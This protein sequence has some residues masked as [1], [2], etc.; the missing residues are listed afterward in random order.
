MAKYIENIRI[1]DSIIDLP[2][3]N[4]A[5]EAETIKATVM[6]WIN[7]NKPENITDV[8]QIIETYGA[9]VVM[10]AYAPNHYSMLPSR[11]SLLGSVKQRG[12]SRP[13]SGR[14]K[15]PEGEKRTMRSMK[16]TDAEW[17]KIK[18]FAREV[19]YQNTK[20]DIENV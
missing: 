19:K 8:L 20:G 9:M 2:A 3:M 11:G 12:G 10:S 1:F 4:T 14:P 5:A 15:L 6:G 7:E 18:E 17:E 16:A 13:G